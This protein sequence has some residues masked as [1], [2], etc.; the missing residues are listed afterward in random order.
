MLDT[1]DGEEMMIHHPSKQTQYFSRQLT[2]LHCSPWPDSHL[3]FIRTILNHEVCAL[4]LGFL[5]QCERLPGLLRQTRGSGS[6]DAGEDT[7]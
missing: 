3:L 2:R 5:S 7:S 4:S 6:S 1:D